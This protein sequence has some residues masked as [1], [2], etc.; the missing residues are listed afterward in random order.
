MEPL[1]PETKRQILVDR[2]NANC[3]DI[4]EYE[5]L[6]AERFTEDP[7]LPKSSTEA[8]AAG[9]RQNRLEQLYKKLFGSTTM[10]C[11]KKMTKG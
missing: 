4:E 9:K 10:D 5:R 2:P 7:D 1:K 8:R 11:E 3:A 6:L